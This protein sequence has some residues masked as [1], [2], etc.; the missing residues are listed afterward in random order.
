MGV[1][2]FPPGGGNLNREISLVHS[3]LGIT[4]FIITNVTGSK[5]VL[6]RAF[7]GRKYLYG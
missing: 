6:E 2:P 5:G 7:S 1:V 4:T 3:F